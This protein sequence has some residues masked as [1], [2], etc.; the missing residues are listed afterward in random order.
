MKKFIKKGKNIPTITLQHII[1]RT[2]YNKLT[3]FNKKS[4]SSEIDN[5]QKVTISSTLPND[6]LINKT[7]KETLKDISYQE[8][9]DREFENFLHKMQDLMQ[10]E[11]QSQQIISHYINEINFICNQGREP[12]KDILIHYQLTS[13][14]LGPEPEILSQTFLILGRCFKSREKYFRNYNDYDQNDLLN[15]YRLFNLVEDFKYFLTYENSFITYEQIANSLIGLRDCGYK[16]TQLIELVI[17]NIKKFLNIQPIKEEKSGYLPYGAGRY[18]FFPK[19]LHAEDII[20]DE[21]FQRHLNK[22]ITIESKNSKKKESLTEEDKELFKEEL[23]IFKEIEEILKEIDNTKHVITDSAH[24]LVSQ[25]IH[26]E[27]LFLENPELYNNQYIKYELLKLQDKLIESGTL[28]PDT[29]MKVTNRLDEKEIEEIK[30]EAVIKNIKDFA[31][32]NYPSLYS[33]AIDELTNRFIKEEVNQI[34]HR[35][36]EENRRSKIRKGFGKCIHSLK[37]YSKIT[38]LDINGEDYI[39]KDILHN[40]NINEDKSIKTTAPYTKLYVIV[41]EFFKDFNKVNFLEDSTLEDLIYLKSAQIPENE[42]RNNKSIGEKLKTELIKEAEFKNMNLLAELLYSLSPDSST[43]NRLI[44]IITKLS[45]SE[46][47]VEITVEDNLKILS[48]LSVFKL[49][50]SN[51]FLHLLRQ[52]VKSPENIKSYISDCYNMNDIEKLKIIS[53]VSEALKYEVSKDIKIPNELFP[54]LNFNLNYFKVNANSPKR[55]DFNKDLFLSSLTSY[56]ENIISQKYKTGF[57]VKVKD[58]PFNPEFI[59]GYYGSKVALFITAEGESSFNEDFVQRILKDNFGIYSV[60]INLKD[61]IYFDKTTLTTTINDKIFEDTKDGSNFIDNLISEVKPKLFD[62]KKLTSCSKKLHKFINKLSDSE[63]LN[64]QFISEQKESDTINS[65]LNNLYELSNLDS[66]LR[67]LSDNKSFLYKLEEINISMAKWQESYKNLEE[68]SFKQILNN[69]TPFDKLLEELKVNYSKNYIAINNI[70]KERKNDSLISNNFVSS[71]VNIDMPIVE[72]IKE[73]TLKEKGIGVEFIN[74][75]YLQIGEYNPYKDWEVSLL[76]TYDHFNYFTNKKENIYKFNSHKYGNRT[77]PEG[78]FPHPNRI[79]KIK[80]PE[81]VQNEKEKSHENVY[82]K[83]LSDFRYLNEKIIHEEVLKNKQLKETIPQEISMKVNLLNI[84]N[85]LKQNLNDNEIIH[86]IANFEFI[87]KLIEEHNSQVKKIELKNSKS[88]ADNI[89]YV[90]RNPNDYLDMVR[91]VSSLNLSNVSEYDRFVMKEYYNQEKLNEVNP[92]LSPEENRKTMEERW[93]RKVEME[94]DNDS[95]SIY[96]PNVVEYKFNIKPIITNI[97]RET[98]KESEELELFEKDPTKGLDY[99]R[100]RAERNLILLKISIKCLKSEQLNQD[101]IEFLKKLTQGKTLLDFHNSGVLPTLT[102]LKLKDLSAVDLYSLQ[103]LHNVEFNSN[104]E[105]Y[106]LNELILEFSNFIDNGSVMK[107]VTQL[108]EQTAQNKGKYYSLLHNKNNKEQTLLSHEIQEQLWR[109]AGEFDSDDIQKLKTILKVKK[110][111][112]RFDRIWLQYDE[113]SLEDFITTCNKHENRIEYLSEWVQRKEKEIENRINLP[114]IYN[115]MVVSDKDINDQLVRKDQAYRKKIILKNIFK[116]DE[117]L[118]LSKN[119]V[120]TFINEFITS[121]Y[122][123]NFKYPDIVKDIFNSLEYDLDH[124]MTE[125]NKQLV[126]HFRLFFKIDEENPSEYLA[127]LP[128]KMEKE[129]L[130]QRSSND[131]K[132]SFENRIKVSSFPLM[133]YIANKMIEHIK[134]NQKKH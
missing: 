63:E 38:S 36:K 53:I 3:N 44:E 129:C 127:V 118:K 11:K 21:N 109:K 121:L 30:R 98:S 6:G 48:T 114:S 76:N 86:F 50:G 54:L 111:K 120:T 123:F 67:T 41:Q 131:E 27:Q 132:S 89:Q 8:I 80:I 4:F 23:K 117:I 39:N 125:E 52:L 55:A 12:L 78:V 29:I 116:T 37:E 81:Y 73:Q 94:E 32:F 82:L 122:G 66:E 35:T 14:Q 70:D 79:R 24:N 45:H 68:S 97:T 101:E 124:A 26:L 102:S 40:H 106:S 113:K 69:I 10:R 74:N 133:S 51:L 85:S 1:K 9:H 5:P 134:Q 20:Y 15:S 115:G 130:L 34:N 99:V 60:F 104:H 57:L 16:N 2:Q 56:F 31:S 22:L 100:R 43:D 58:I 105:N 126:K 19:N 13:N 112:S 90:S 84:S 119:E 96:N 49:Y 108:F 92:N 33:E 107:I 72:S 75:N 42:L 71:R 93:G 61:Y 25:Y 128:I 47:N 83:E 46:L 59:I 64:L 77:V 17:K 18:D 87:D 95:I 62:I 103:S 65:F 110:D 28:T 88:E 7:Y 91:R